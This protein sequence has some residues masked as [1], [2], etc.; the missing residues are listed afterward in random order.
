VLFG[1]GG[2]GEDAAGIGGAGMNGVHLIAGRSSQPENGRR[3]K[4]YRYR[5]WANSRCRSSP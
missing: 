5:T 3:A 2:L 4:A 1:V